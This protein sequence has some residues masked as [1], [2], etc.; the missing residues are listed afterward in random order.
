[1]SNLWVGLAKVRPQPG[2]DA[3][4]DSYGAVV[5]VV[6]PASSADDFVRR[7]TEALDAVGFE[8]SSWEDVSE[9]GRE[10]PPPDAMPSL[11]E[12]ARR[13]ESQQTVAWGDFHAF[14]A[15]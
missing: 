9:L 12:A 4:A 1:V 13:A 3:L 6:S 11:V 8:A 10:W 7:A 14:P 15:E 5:N 2:N